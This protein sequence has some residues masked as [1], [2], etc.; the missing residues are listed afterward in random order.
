MFLTPFTKQ[1]LKSS[2]SAKETHLQ[3]LQNEVGYLKKSLDDVKL[4][5]KQKSDEVIVERGNVATLSSHLE[6]KETNLVNMK[7]DMK[8]EHQRVNAQLKNDLSALKQEHA[9]LL[10]QKQTLESELS[11]KR[12]KL[13]QINTETIMKVES[14]RRDMETSVNSTALENSKLHAKVSDLVFKL[15]Q[16][17]LDLANLNEHF[18]HTK[19]LHKHEITIIKQES[20]AHMRKCSILDEGMDELKKMYQETKEQ[21]EKV[22]AEMA[23]L[24]K[25]LDVREEELSDEQAEICILKTKLEKSSKD[26]LET[27]TKNINDKDRLQS[28]ISILQSKLESERRETKELLK[29]AEKNFKSQIN[30]EKRKAECYKEKAIDAHTKKLHIKQLLIQQEGQKNDFGYLDK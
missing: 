21:L 10:K 20:D 12:A 4:S 23:V 19:V 1:K 13:K 25:K 8:L 15:N 14:T 11:D 22:S 26:Q 6:E 9:L 2:Y 3:S 29:E 5:L 18:A 28:E 17:E 24:Q 16:R 7:E 30:R 27:E